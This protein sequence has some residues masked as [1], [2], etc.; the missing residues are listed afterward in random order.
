MHL[1]HLNA[2]LEVLENGFE[3]DVQVEQQEAVM[4][5]PTIRHDHSPK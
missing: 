2:V 1:E 5:F 3:P 4:V